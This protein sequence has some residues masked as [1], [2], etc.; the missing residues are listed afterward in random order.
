MGNSYF[1]RGGWVAPSLDV[2]AFSG[3]WRRL[4]IRKVFAC[5]RLSKFNLGT[6]RRPCRSLGSRELEDQ[7]NP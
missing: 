5:C 2:G 7:K 4:D 6:L 3:Q 1:N